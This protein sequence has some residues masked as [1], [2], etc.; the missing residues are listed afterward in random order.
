MIETIGLVIAGRVWYH[1]H[2]DGD[3]WW[4]MLLGWF[5]VV[6]VVATAVVV[7]AHILR[8]DGAGRV[9][10]RSAEEVLAERFARGEIDE[11]EFRKR[12]DA[13]RG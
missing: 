3:W 1:D 9:G 7:A 8:R 4:A 2:M 10:Y 13:L 12:R 5:L 11:D 6:V